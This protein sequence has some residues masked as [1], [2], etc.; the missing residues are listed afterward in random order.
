MKLIAL[1]TPL[2]LASGEPSSVNFVIQKDD[3][4]TVQ[5]SIPAD[6]PRFAFATEAVEAY[7]AQSI[8]SEELLHALLSNSSLH[9]LLETKLSLVEGILD[10]RM[11]VVGRNVL[12]DGDPI[13]PVLEQFI[14][15]LLAENSTTSSIRGW[16]AFAH[17]VEKLYTNQS[18]SV[19]KQFFSWLGAEIFSGTGS[20]TLTED[21]DVIGYKGCA[22]TVAAPTS[23]NTGEAYVNGELKRGAIPNP[24]GAVVTMARSEVQDDPAIGCSVG[25]HVGTY[26]YAS[27]FSQGVLVKVRFN[28]RDVVSVPTECS[29]QKL[30]VCRYEVL[31]VITAP[32][33][34][35]VYS[36]AMSAEQEEAYSK[37]VEVLEA[38]GVDEGMDESEYPVVT[39]SY[40]GRTRTVAAESVWKANGTAYLGALEGEQYKTYRLDRLSDLA[41]DATS[42]EVEQNDEHQLIAD[43]IEDDSPLLFTYHGKPRLVLPVRLYNVRGTWLL[44]AETDGKHRTFKVAEMED[45]DFAPAT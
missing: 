9:Y 25:L 10:G 37:L 32:D 17:F 38:A 21:G 7:K 29:A 13:D 16:T 3:Q 23:I 2:D 12:V 36:P 28:P 45:L 4:E 26:G 1:T 5:D 24:L 27:S 8:T 34:S 42:P 22:G 33:Y 35:A 44:L 19:R 15:K 31:E 6:S 14:L 39:F 41:V 43:A 30:R 40:A 18:E 20:F 11:A